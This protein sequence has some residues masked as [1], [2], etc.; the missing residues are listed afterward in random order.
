MAREYRTILFKEHS[1]WSAS[2][3][4]VALQEKLNTFGRQGWELVATERARVGYTSL[5][6]IF[7]RPT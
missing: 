6:L 4:E 3:D 7:K 5:L 1:F 2:V